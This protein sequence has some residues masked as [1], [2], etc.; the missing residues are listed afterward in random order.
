[1]VS[2]R[3]VG[4]EPGSDD[5]VINRKKV[6]DYIAA[7]TPTLTSPREQAAVRGATYPARHEVT[8]KYATYATTDDLVSESTKYFMIGD[9]GQNIASLTSG[10][11]PSAQWPTS[12]RRYVEPQGT[13]QETT[14]IPMALN[15]YSDITITTVT[16]DGGGPWSWIPFVSGAIETLT[17]GWTVVSI[18]VRDESNR[19]VAEGFSSMGSRSMVSLG[20]RSTPTYN[21]SQTFRIQGRI[22]SG[23]GE[24]TVTG[25][26]GRVLFI[27]VPA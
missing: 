26:W 3:Y 20:A 9:I 19:V 16:L 15:P 8:N 17:G 18:F 27:P 23:T 7:A 11:L 13:R 25:W 22:V 24:G 21:G 2:L 10:E 14:L 5:G 1:M 12:Y 6:N 4:A